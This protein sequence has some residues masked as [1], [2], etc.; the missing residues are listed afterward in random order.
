MKTRINTMSGAA[1][2]ASNKSGSSLDGDFLHIAR[3]LR[4]LL[5]SMAADK[6]A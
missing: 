6:P 2:R 3:Q 1:L 5:S 4:E